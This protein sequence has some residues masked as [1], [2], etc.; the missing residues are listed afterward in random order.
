MDLGTGHAAYTLHAQEAQRAEREREYRRIAKERAVLQQA[1]L[2]V[3]PQRQHRF[4]FGT[5]FRG[6]IRSAQ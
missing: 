4:H 3:R 6:R 2:P 1:E 5:M